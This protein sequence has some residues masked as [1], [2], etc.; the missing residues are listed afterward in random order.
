MIGA[1]G[2]INCRSERTR[3]NHKVELRD[4]DWCS[5]AVNYQSDRARRNHKVERRDSDGS[6]KCSKFSTGSRGAA[7][8]LRPELMFNG[9]LPGILCKF[10]FS[11]L[12]RRV[13]FGNRTHRGSAVF[14]SC[15]MLC[16]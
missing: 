7:S 3:R 2:A 1:S 10:T 14:I 15:K 16:R 12:W 5:N 13:L 8:F 4:Y 9:L 6:S 11:N